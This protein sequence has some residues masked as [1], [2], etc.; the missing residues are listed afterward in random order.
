MYI[1]IFIMLIIFFVFLYNL[2]YVSHDNFVIT[3][4]DI[5]LSKIFNLAFIAS[6]VALFFARIC[7]V[8]FN[9][10]PQYLNLLGFLAF[11][12]FPG[13][14]LIGGM[15]GGLSFVSLY[16]KA[17]KLPVGKII[18]LFTISFI[19][20]LPIGFIAFFIAN[21]GKTSIIFNS[22]FLASIVL[23]IVFI[24]IV[25]KFAEKGEIKDGSLSLI[26]ISIFTLIYFIVRLFVTLKDFSFFNVETIVLFFII[27]SSLIVL[28]NHEIM[29]KILEK[30]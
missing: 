9:P 20:V 11:P 27:F 14:S 15:V 4:K 3:R 16:S 6:I 10:S 23:C 30:K 7:F 25:F 2:Y 21:L 5:P 22:L 1:N 13:L 29:E 24:K 17:N 19:S 26:F 8:I 18:D 28:V 12:Y